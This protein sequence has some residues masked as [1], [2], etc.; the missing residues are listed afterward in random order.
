MFVIHSQIGIIEVSRQTCFKL[1]DDGY[2]LQTEMLAIKSAAKYDIKS[3]MA[4][5]LWLLLIYVF[6][7]STLFLNVEHL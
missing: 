7:T 2:I 1:S 6:T 5:R 4:K 3:F